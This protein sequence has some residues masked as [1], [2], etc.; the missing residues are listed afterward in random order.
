MT[1]PAEELPVGRHLLLWDAPNLDMTLSN[2]IDSKPTARERPNL[3]VLGRWLVERAAAA[4]PPGEAEAC[5]FVNVA[6]HVAGPM[7]GWVMWLL[8]EG[9][10][11]FAKPKVAD[12]DVDRDMLDHIERRQGEGDLAAVLVG[13]ND[14]RNFLQPLERLADR[15]IDVTVLGFA[16]FAGA[17]SSS[18]QL[19]FLD[20]EQ[21]EGLFEQPLPRINLEMLPPQGRW[22]EPTGALGAGTGRAAVGSVHADTPASDLT[23]AL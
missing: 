23:A 17:L 15:G 2:I 3:D 13:S 22:F 5:V 7:R 4:T 18:E 11:V 19:R 21:I 16:E 8:E 12:S 10:R 14:A 1:T 20:L 9:F 6:P